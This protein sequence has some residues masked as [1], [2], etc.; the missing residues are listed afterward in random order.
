MLEIPRSA[1]NV[2][3]E[4]SRYPQPPYYT[5]QI[6]HLLRL[7]DF[8]ILSMIDQTILTE[9]GEDYVVYKRL[10]NSFGVGIEIRYYPDLSRFAFRIYVRNSSGKYVEQAVPGLSADEARI[11]TVIKAANTL[12]GESR[13]KKTPKK[14]PKAKERMRKRQPSSILM[15]KNIDGSMRRTNVIKRA[16]CKGFCTVDKNL[17]R[18]NT[19]SV[20]NP[21]TENVYFLVEA[22]DY[23]NRSF[24]V[25]LK[26]VD[27]FMIAIQYNPNCIK[28][29]GNDH[30]FDTGN[31]P[32]D[33]GTINTNDMLLLQ[34]AIK[35]LTT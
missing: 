1:L 25:L 13:K 7:S 12:R 35:I 3:I 11:N 20:V 2:I 10:Y 22:L 32:L 26:D 4:D 9:N 16:I 30:L 34:E 21:D 14:D 28:T 29:I 27:E 33:L 17:A 31:T 18:V 8:T 5:C 24:I 15:I 6:L 23:Y 19:E